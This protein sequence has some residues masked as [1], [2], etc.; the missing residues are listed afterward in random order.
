MLQRAAVTEDRLAMLLAAM[1]GDP[2]APPS[3]VHE[4][5]ASLAEHYKRREYLACE[6]MGALVRENIQSIRLLVASSAPASAAEGPAS[7]GIGV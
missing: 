5:R 6:S 4:L 3:H 2:L 7:P 1:S